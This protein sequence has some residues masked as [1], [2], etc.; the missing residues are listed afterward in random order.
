MAVVLSA[1]SVTR[2]EMLVGFTLNGRAGN[3]LAETGTVVA[4]NLETA[5]PY[6]R[7]T[8]SVVAASAAGSSFTSSGWTTNG[9]STI[10]TA[11]ASNTYYTIR[12]APVAGTPTVTNFSV[13]AQ[14]SAT[15]P[16]NMTLRSSVDNFASDPDL[17][18]SD[19]RG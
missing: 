14:R 3:Q 16:T 17:H 8:R 13:R 18:E 11:I 4:A 2:A 19:H 6:I 5:A 7:I 12:L 10:T 15:G 9:A 1:A